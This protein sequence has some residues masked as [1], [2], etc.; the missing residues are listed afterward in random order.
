MKKKCFSIYSSRFLLT[1]GL[2]ISLSGC[3]GSGFGTQNSNWN[4]ITGSVRNYGQY[5]TPNLRTCYVTNLV[6]QG[7][8]NLAFQK[9]RQ[10]IPTIILVKNYLIPSANKLFIQG[11]AQPLN[12]LYAQIQPPTLANFMIGCNEVVVKERKQ[13]IKERIIW[14]QYLNTTPAPQPTNETCTNNYI[15]NTNAFQAAE[16]IANLYMTNPLANYINIKGVNSFIIPPPLH[17]QPI[18]LVGLETMHMNI[19]Q[20]HK[21]LQQD[22]QQLQQEHQQLQNM[23]IGKN[24]TA[25]ELLTS[26]NNVATDGKNVKAALSGAINYEKA[27]TASQNGNFMPLI[28]IYKQVHPPTWGNFFATC[29]QGTQQAHLKGKVDNI[30]KINMH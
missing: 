13:L 20:L 23:K 8:Y 14:Q 19:K 4:N 15:L 25:Q 11:N 27:V 2:A 16:D 6:K 18:T 24:V 7:L 9:A 28:A 30:A 5:P 26:L 17:L 21:Q 10:G 12:S 29:Y 22:L 3:A 1:L